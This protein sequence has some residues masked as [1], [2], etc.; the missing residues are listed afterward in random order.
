MRL[1]AK[2]FHKGRKFSALQFFGLDPPLKSSDGKIKSGL[3]D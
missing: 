3:M 2:E 1:L